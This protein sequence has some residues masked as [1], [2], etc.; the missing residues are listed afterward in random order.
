MKVEKADQ[1]WECHECGK[2]S[3]DCIW[4]WLANLCQHV[5]SLCPNCLKKLKKSLKK[6]KVVLA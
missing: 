4:I 6:V 5:V 1:T 3:D 2:T